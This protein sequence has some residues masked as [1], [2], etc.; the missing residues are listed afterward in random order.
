MC[1]LLAHTSA[2]VSLPIRLVGGRSKSEG[3]VEVLHA[4]EWGSICDDQWDDSDAEVVC[5]QLGLRLSVLT[6]THT[7]DTHSDTN[8]HIQISIKEI[9]CWCDRSKKKMCGRK[10]E[11]AAGNEFMWV[12][13]RLS[14]PLSPKVWQ[15]FFLFRHAERGASS[16]E[17]LGVRQW[18]RLIV[19]ARILAPQR[20]AYLAA[21]Y[22][23]QTHRNVYV[24]RDVRDKQFPDIK[25]DI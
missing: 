23:E 6:C 9:H 2:G 17:H 21:L 12:S 18:I 3:R 25:H 13:C 5:R 10:I 1:F 20:Y 22:R 19:P 8:V 16:K 7:H 15:V 14:L 11:K 24:C 4:G